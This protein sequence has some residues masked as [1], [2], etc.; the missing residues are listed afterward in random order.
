MTTYKTFIRS[1]TDWDSFSSARKI[2]KYTNLSESEA[3]DLCKRYN[4]S[5]TAAQIRKG[6]KMEFTEE[7]GRRTRRNKRRT[8]Q[9]NGATKNPSTT[10]WLLIGGAVVAAGV[11]Y[12]FYSQ[13]Q[14]QLAL[15]AAAKKVPPVGSP[16]DQI[17]KNIA[18]AQADIANY[19]PKCS[20]GSQG[21][22][23][24]VTAAQK[25]I[26]ASEAQWSQICG[27]YVR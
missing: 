2:T 20:G 3:R 19:T 23:D 24:I 12:Y 6:T 17:K 5:R 10:T 26:T 9:R 13:R 27:Q 16:C 4:D 25:A 22:C 15:E 18:S 21:A 8:F 1:A 7:R 14:K 11:G